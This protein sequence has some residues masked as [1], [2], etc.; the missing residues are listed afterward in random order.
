MA[1][2]RLIP[3]LHVLWRVVCSEAT[4]HTLSFKEFVKFCP[5]ELIPTIGTEAF[6]ARAML[7]LSAGSKGLVG[8]EDLIFGAEEGDARAARVVVCEDDNN[9]CGPPDSAQERG[10]TPLSGLP[11][12]IC[13]FRHG[14]QVVFACSHES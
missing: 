4:H 11:Y 1:Q 9:I 12:Q 6:D 14:L 7:L 3:L 2:T 10:P 13:P 5:G 8:F